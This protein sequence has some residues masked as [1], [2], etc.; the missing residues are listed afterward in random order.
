MLTALY[1][2]YTLALLTCLVFA[3]RWWRVRPT[4]YGVLFL[5]VLAGLVYDNLIIALGARVGEGDL[6]KTLSAGR[7][8]LHGLLTP[9][10]V[11]FAFG[12]LR[13]AGVGWAQSGWAHALV[14][15]V[16]SALIGYGVYRDIILLDLQPVVQLDI[17]RYTSAGSKGP[18]IGS[19]GTILVLIGLGASL[20]RKTGWLWLALGALAM[21]VA[22]GVGTG[23]RLF[24]ANLGEVILGISLLVTGLRFFEPAVRKPAG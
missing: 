24:L 11:I 2:F 10:L 12:V 21:F 6:L 19:I 17:L 9:V 8:Y 23:E 1:A 4:S 22:A 20:W 16:A 5:V 3:V 15:L 13:Q 18:P 14:C 7:F